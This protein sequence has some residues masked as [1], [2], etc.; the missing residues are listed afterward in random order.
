[1][2]FWR[3]RHTFKKPHHS[4]LNEMDSSSSSS[5]GKKELERLKQYFASLEQVELQEEVLPSH[6]N[7]PNKAIPCDH[8]NQNTSKTGKSAGKRRTRSHPTC[9]Q[10][11]PPEPGRAARTTSAC[12]PAKPE[13]EQAVTGGGFD[14]VDILHLFT[15]DTPCKKPRHGGALAAA[16]SLM[17]TPAPRAKRNPIL[18]VDHDHEHQEDVGGAGAA[19]DGPHPATQSTIAGTCTLPN[20]SSHS[21]A[22]NGAKAGKLEAAAA[23]HTRAPLRQ[24]TALPSWVPPSAPTRSTSAP[25]RA[26]L[27]PRPCGTRAR[28]QNRSRGTAAAARPEARCR[29]RTSSRRSASAVGLTPDNTSDSDSNALPSD[30]GLNSSTNSSYESRQITPAS[31]PAETAT[32]QDNSADPERD[33]MSG[34]ATASGTDIS[35]SPS[36]SL[37]ANPKPK[38]KT[39]KSMARRRPEMML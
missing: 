35:T 31:S 25:P 19:S 7:Q 33:A 11:S 26:P 34:N 21:G 4:S 17:K 13:K 3:A 37:H 16:R 5:S 23:R 18:L 15:G 27:T 32:S 8:R 20:S 38:H 10:R 29:P 30:D 14:H 2:W 9:S 6:R 36:S 12:A 22:W 39:R 1:M 24:S 28:L